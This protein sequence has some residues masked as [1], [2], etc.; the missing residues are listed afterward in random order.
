MPGYVWVSLGGALA[1]AFGSLLGKALVRYRICDAGLITWSQGLATAAVA[2]GLCVVL[3]LPFPRTHWF[4]IA[5]LAACIILAS[6]LLNHALQ[7]GDASTVVPLMGLKIPLTALLAWAFLGEIATARTWAAV[8]CS[9]LAVSLFGVGR[10]KPSQGGHGYH[11]LAAIVFVVLACLSYGI[12]DVMAKRALDGVEPLPL[13]LW[14]NVFWAP[15]A[16]AMLARPYY[17]QY[18]VALLDV[19]LLTLRGVLVLGSVLALYF[20]FRMAGGVILPNVIYGTRGVFAL[21]A[22]YVLNKTLRLPM[23]RQSGVIY[24][25]RLA[26]TI[27]LAA[28]VFLSLAA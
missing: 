11:P 23:E 6:W 5:C 22:G 8:A 7:E 16:A 4:P 20:A 13:L 15:V 25:L 17:R 24:A 9:A 2:G 10:Q 14:S 21:A 3:R 12:S 27:L 19:G 28:A 26:G 18:R 1:L